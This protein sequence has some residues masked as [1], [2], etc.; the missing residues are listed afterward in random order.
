MNRD[1]LS[2]IKIEKI[3]YKINPS[4]YYTAYGLRCFRIKIQFTELKIQIITIL[5]LR[6]IHAVTRDRYYVVKI[7]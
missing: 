6:P 1:K 3:N 4:L 2:T 7:V 5:V